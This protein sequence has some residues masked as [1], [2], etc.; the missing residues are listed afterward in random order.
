MSL[1]IMCPCLMGGNSSCVSCMIAERSSGPSEDPSM[2]L[3]V[4]LPSDECQAAATPG[5]MASS[6]GPAAHQSPWPQ[7]AL[8]S[9]A[10][11]QLSDALPSRQQA[12][13]QQPQQQQEQQQQQQHRHEPGQCSAAMQQ[14]GAMPRQHSLQGP[15]ARDVAQ[16]RRRQCLLEIERELLRHSSSDDDA[17]SDS[18]H[19]PNCPAGKC[20]KTACTGRACSAALHNHVVSI[21]SL[22]KNV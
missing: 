7:S 6:T 10:S 4:W 22:D 20:Q 11:R 3:G 21:L 2:S 12:L 1:V 9:I 13:R 8:P 16:R 15:S 19:L 5:L 14:R 18:M 17:P